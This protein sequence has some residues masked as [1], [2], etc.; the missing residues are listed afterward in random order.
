MATIKE[1]LSK[2]TSVDGFVATALVDGDSG[3]VLGSE[4]LGA[5]NLEVAGAANAEVVRAKRKAMTSLALAD[6]IEDILITLGKQYHLIR[7]MKERPMVFFYVVLDRGRANLAL[8]RMH[9]ADAEK[10]LTFLSARR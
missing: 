8:A 6:D 2:L 4:A 5:F 3:M 9:L 10:N 7:P 1:S